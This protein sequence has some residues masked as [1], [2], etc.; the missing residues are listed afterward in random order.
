MTIY[1]I[2]KK[3]G[4]SI[5]TVSRVIN[6]S[7][8]VSKKT[9]D[10]VLRVIEEEKYTPNL[11][12]RNLSNNT[13]HSIGILYSDASDLFLAN[14]V[15]NLEMSFRNRGYDSVL[16]CC[17]YDN[18]R[19][20]NLIN[21]IISKKVDAIV[22]AGSH[23][24][25][26]YEKD[27]DYIRFFSRELPVGILSGKLYDDNIMCA[28]CDDYQAMFD[29]TTSLFHKSSK[30]IAFLY[31]RPSDSIRRKIAG[32]RDAYHANRM[33]FPMEYALRCPEASQAEVSAFIKEA[34]E[35]YGFD[36]MICTDDALAVAV[37]KYAQQNHI[38]VP[39][40]LR[41]VGY[42]NSVLSA[43]TTPELTT[44]DNRTQELSE[45]LAT[46]VVGRL[47]GEKLKNNLFMLPGELIFRE[48]T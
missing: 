14:A 43:C 27:N 16:C 3:A 15:Y 30:K 19:R 28:Y 34:H 21:L 39:G 5:A 11:F 45:A 10:N 17:G 4:V 35:K 32:I 36:S 29:V 47:N 25:E 31:T 48:T 20:A 22:L 12:A 6:G 23:F 42:N 18:P 46:M 7:E 8:R 33:E 41:I 40:E 37:L 9:R 24:V 2:S 13:T 44:V 26:E 38:S 1:D